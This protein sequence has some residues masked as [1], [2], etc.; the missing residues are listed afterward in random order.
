MGVALLR[1]A[2][3]MEIS[4]SVLGDGVVDGLDCRILWIVGR[5]ELDVPFSLGEKV[6]GKRNDLNGV[7]RGLLEDLS[8]LF[9]PDEDGR[10][11]VSSPA[12]IPSMIDELLP[13]CLLL[14][15]VL[16]DGS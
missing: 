2:Q 11:V 5:E 3:S 16:R 13:S 10:E 1:T 4:R 8:L 9:F 6:I 15:L 12:E 7:G 14:R